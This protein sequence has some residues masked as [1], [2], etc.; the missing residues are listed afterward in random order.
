MTCN[1]NILLKMKQINKIQTILF[2]IGG[3]LMVVGAGCAALLS[4]LPGFLPF[5]RVLCWLFLL[6]TILFACVQMMQTYQ[7]SSFVVKRLKRIM[8][9]ADLCFVV[10]G[11]SMVEDNYQFLADFFSQ[12]TEY[13]TLVS[14]KWV[15]LLLIGAVLE[16]Y[17]LHRI[18]HELKKEQ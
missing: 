12:R 11:L 15:V 16:M 4:P 8:T 2:F 1:K 13:L 18:G 14:R 10:A 3:L 9:L 5:M 7:G 17:T 6:G